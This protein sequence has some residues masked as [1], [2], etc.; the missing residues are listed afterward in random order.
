MD[1]V[2]RVLVLEDEPNDA[3]LEIAELENAGFICQWDRV[4]NR[5]SYVEH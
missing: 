2:L 5:E 3:F 4:D 1:N